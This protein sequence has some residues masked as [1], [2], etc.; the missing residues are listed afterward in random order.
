MEEQKK[1]NTE[2]LK[3]KTQD[4]TCSRQELLNV[5]WSIGVIQMLGGEP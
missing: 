5:G 3:K 4:V 1:K 2:G